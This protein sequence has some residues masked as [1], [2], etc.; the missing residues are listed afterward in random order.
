[1]HLLYRIPCI[2]GIKNQNTDY[3]YR[4]LCLSLCFSVVKFLRIEKAK[5]CISSTVA[6]TLT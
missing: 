5:C 3:Q 6:V 1:M 4:E 2:H